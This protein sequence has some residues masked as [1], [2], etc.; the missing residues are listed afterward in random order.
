MLLGVGYPLVD[1]VVRLSK[2]EEEEE[3]HPPLLRRFGLRYGDAAVASEQHTPLYKELVDGTHGAPTYV[4]GGSTLNTCRITQWLLDASLSSSPSSPSPYRGATAFL[5]RIGRDSFADL[6]ESCMVSD[7]VRP[8]LERPPPS[9]PSPLPTGTSAVLVSPR[10][11]ERALLTYLGASRHM[12][13]A[14]VRTDPAVSAAVS[15]ALVVY[16]CGFM[17]Q[18]AA[19]EHFAVALHAAR[20]AVDAGHRVGVNLSAVYVAREFTD[21]L[22]QLVELASYVFGNEGEA[23]AFSEGMGWAGAEWAGEGPH[24]PQGAGAAGGREEP[25]SGAEAAVRAVAERIAALPRP[26]GSVPRIVAITRGAESTVVVD[27]S[28]RSLAVLVPPVERVVDATGAGDAFVGGFLAATL[29]GHRPKIA[30]RV[31]HWAS[32][33][34]IGEVGVCFDRGLMCPLLVD[35]DDDDRD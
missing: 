14:F 2:E 29:L 25:V 27:G 30:A 7:G 33:R 28:G 34:V 19:P 13:E 16:T 15:S 6:L 1:I 21:R 11:G 4:A 23:L 10:D 8:L 22:R 18:S 24:A 31:G 26:P 20:T 9:D 17:V 35:E 32:A 12:T 3:D 5:G